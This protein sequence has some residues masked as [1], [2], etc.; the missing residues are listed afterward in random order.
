MGCTAG[1][2]LSFATVVTGLLS[3]PWSTGGGS[4]LGVHSIGM[5]T[6]PSTVG[7]DLLPVAAG[8]IVFV[9]AVVGFDAVV[10]AEVAV[11]EML[12]PSAAEIKPS[13]V[14]SLAGTGSPL[15]LTMLITEAVTFPAALWLPKAML[16]SG[17]LPDKGEL[18]IMLSLIVPGVLLL[19]AN[20]AS[21][22]RLP[23]LTVGLPNLAVS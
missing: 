2:V 20:S 14:V 15:L 17:P 16:A 18:W 5:A 23:K 22:V 19:A 12:L 11:P 10:V 6:L 7:I 1:S 3:L 9:S 4:C 13:L 21:E 8:L